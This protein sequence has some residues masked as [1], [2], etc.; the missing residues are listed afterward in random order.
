MSTQLARQSSSPAAENVGAGELAA[1]M[2]P[3]KRLKERN[4]NTESSLG[5]SRSIGRN[6]RSGLLR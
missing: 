1:T 6:D 2:I 5:T 4:Y 3:R